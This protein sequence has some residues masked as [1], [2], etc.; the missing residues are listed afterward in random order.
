MDRLRKLGQHACVCGTPTTG[1]SCANLPHAGVRAALA[2]SPDS[3]WLVS[4]CHPDESLQI[5]NVATAQLAT[6][7]QGT[8]DATV[9]QAIA[10]SPDGARIAAA[11]ADGSARIMECR[12][13]RGGPLIPD[14]HGHRRQEVAGLQSGR[15]TP[16]GYG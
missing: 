12:D 5:W 6:K 11:D 9:V 14:G 16:R 7:V 2:F 13:R 10:V 8:A 15:T 4:G 3:S 1:E